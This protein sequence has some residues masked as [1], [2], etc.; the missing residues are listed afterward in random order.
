MKKN[1]IQINEERLKEILR[2]AV[3]S[4]L[5]EIDYRTA[6]IPFISNM[7]SNDEL[8]RGNAIETRQNGDKKSIRDKRD[9]SSSMIYKVLTQGIKDN[10]G[11]NFV[12]MFGRK[13]EDMTTSNV[14]FYF[15]ELKLLTP[16]RFVIEGYANLSRSPISIGKAKPKKIQIDYRFDTQQFYEAVYCA[17]KTVR[18]MK[19]LNLDYAGDEGRENVNIAKKLI[20]FLS[21][22]LYSIEDGESRILD[23]E[24]SNDEIVNP[25]MGK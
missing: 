9:R 3:K 25:I 1:I 6:V 17:N 19:K 8:L 16:K 14:D 15:Q 7:N 4:V 12:L 20:Q 2:E 11:E 18:D 10:I 23:K 5:T 13:E 24:P 22:C 21:M